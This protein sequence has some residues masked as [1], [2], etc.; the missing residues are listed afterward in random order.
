M[1]V[2][3]A[4]GF[5]RNPGAHLRRAAVDVFGAD[6]ERAANRGPPARPP[7]PATRIRHVAQ[8]Q[9]MPSSCGATAAQVAGSAKR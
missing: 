7:A 9:G 6:A 1:R 3:C 2:V 5:A 8:P 4:A